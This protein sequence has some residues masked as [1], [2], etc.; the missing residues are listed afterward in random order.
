M[1]AIA[2]TPRASRCSHSSRAQLHGGTRVE[3][4]NYATRG[5]ATMERVLT[6]RSSTIRTI[7]A[8]STDRNA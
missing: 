4:E 8:Q 3:R 7:M 6:A 2:A 1:H 5:A